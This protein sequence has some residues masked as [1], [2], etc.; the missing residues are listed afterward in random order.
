MMVAKGKLVVFEGLDHTGKGTQIRLAM[1]WLAAKGVAAETHREPGGTAV[2]ERVRGLL[3]DP[4]LKEM[5]PKTEMLLFFASR[6][7]LSEER[8]GPALEKGTTV[9]LDRYYFS[10]AAYQGPHLT[11]GAERV[12]WLAR[13]L[14]LPEPDLVVC[15]DGDPERLA[16]RHTGPSDRIEAK[17]LEFQR[18]VRKAYFAM[19]KSFP[20][21]RLVDAERPVEAVHK[22][23]SGLLEA[24]LGKPA[25]RAPLGA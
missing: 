2:G 11:G 22:E 19:A 1:D 13:Q 12:L 4:D 9:V 17:G 23:V 7:Q 8:V 15:L 10:T 6:A 16:E 21:F 20:Y 24:A 3:L 14:Q 25:E 18:G 5:K